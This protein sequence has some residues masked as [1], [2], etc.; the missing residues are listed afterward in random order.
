MPYKK[1]SL[2]I[3]VFALCF[4]LSSLFFHSNQQLIS[5]LNTSLGVDQLAAVSATVMVIDPNS[6]KVIVTPTTVEFTYSGSLRGDTRVFWKKHV[7]TIWSHK[8]NLDD[9]TDVHDIFI[10]GFIPATTYDYYVASKEPTLAGKYGKSVIK[11]FTT[12]N[13]SA[14]TINDLTET[15]SGGLAGKTTFKFTTNHLSDCYF[16]FKSTLVGF[17]IINGNI[18]GGTL[19]SDTH[20]KDDPALDRVDQHTFYVS[21][22]FIGPAGT[23]GY[24]AFSCRYQPF[25]DQSWHP[26]INVTYPIHTFYVRA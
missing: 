19:L 1:L 21:N 14:L 7:D 23:R 4:S 5:S 11:P 25:Y 10:G 22:Q 16:E 13:P 6:M 8:F 15:S 17:S 18:F 12:L 24:Y 2:S 26:L 20:T 9:R 3:G